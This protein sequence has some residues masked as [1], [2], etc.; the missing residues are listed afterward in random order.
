M[1][2]HQRGLIRMSGKF[3]T[4]EKID[5]FRHITLHEARAWSWSFRHCI[6]NTSAY[7]HKI[8]FILDNMSLAL[9]ATKGRTGS[10]LIAGTLREAAS[11][12]LATG[13]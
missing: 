4:Q 3:C 7:G 10:A 2:S 5:Q 8:L 6:R 11:H 9:A 13:C 12:M 1:K